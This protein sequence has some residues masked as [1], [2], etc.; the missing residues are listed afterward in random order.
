MMH[1]VYQGDNWSNMEGKIKYSEIFHSVQGEGSLTGV[2]S[3]FFRTS[4]CNLRCS[5]CDT[6]YTSHEP[7][8]KDITI[9]E[10]VSEISKYNCN[11]VVITGGEPFIQKESLSYLCSILKSKGKHITIETN[12]TIYHPVPADL[13]SLSPKTSNS[14]PTKD[15]TSDG[16][17][18][19]HERKRVNVKSLREF[20]QFYNH[21]FKFV[22]NF[23]EDIE[24]IDHIIDQ[25]GIDPDKV[26]LMP[27]GL[28]TPEILQKE[29]WLVAL[30][31]GKN[32]RY[33]DRLH[34]RL[35]SDRRGV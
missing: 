32:Y 31:M 22:V 35:W 30:C 24:E 8:N 21:Q 7:E 25:V 2:P 15:Q 4:F 5:W 18:K 34:V 10:A 16:L 14:T 1:K 17:I 28:T 20:I 26:F 27:E 19:V 3:V 29:Y 11:H 13:I 12:G 9:E 23:P 6:P 33:S